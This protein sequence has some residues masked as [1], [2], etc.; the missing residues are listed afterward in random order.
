MAIVCYELIIGDVVQERHMIVTLPCVGYRTVRPI[1][2]QV[3]MLGIL[4]DVFAVLR[5]VVEVGVNP[6]LIRV[7]FDGVRPRFGDKCC[8]GPKGLPACL[9]FKNKE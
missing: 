1:L 4:R 7:V 5:P 3:R 9:F 8:I 2:Y 6:H